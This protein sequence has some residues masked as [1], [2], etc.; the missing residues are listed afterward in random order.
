MPGTCSES[1]QFQRLYDL[2]GNAVGE[3]VGRSAGLLLHVDR[4]A[5]RDVRREGWTRHDGLK[6]D[7]MFRFGE[8]ATAGP[9]TAVY[10]AGCANGSRK[11]KT[12]A[13][14]DGWTLLNWDGMKAAGMAEAKWMKATP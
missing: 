4:N 14:G 7:T 9:G 8:Y 1:R 12:D 5:A 11:V 3:V 13:R 6:S 10:V 2:V